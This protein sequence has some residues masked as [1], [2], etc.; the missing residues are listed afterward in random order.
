LRVPISEVLPT[1]TQRSGG[2]QP[3]ALIVGV[4]PSIPSISSIE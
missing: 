2:S 4:A 1:A 3:N